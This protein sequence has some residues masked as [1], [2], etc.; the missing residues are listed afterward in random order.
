[1]NLLESAIAR[2]R[3]REE[4]AT[5]RSVP[6]FE[7]P[8]SAKAQVPPC[9][10]C[11]AMLVNPALRNLLLALGHECPKPEPDERDV[12]LVRDDAKREHFRTD[13]SALTNRSMKFTWDE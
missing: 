4:R 3:K 5:P 9:V 1:M 13:V 6:H 10:V 8:E 12:K 2:L 11:Y 7:E